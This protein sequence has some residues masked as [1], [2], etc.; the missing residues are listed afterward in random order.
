MHDNSNGPNID[1]PCIILMIH[2][3]GSHESKSAAIFVNSMAGILIY[4]T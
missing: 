1:T 2:H 4:L 3:F